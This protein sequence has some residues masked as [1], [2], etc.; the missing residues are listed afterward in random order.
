MI[1]TS[2]HLLRK[3]YNKCIAPASLQS[4][5]ILTGASSAAAAIVHRYIGCLFTC[6][7]AVARVLFSGPYLSLGAASGTAG[8]QRPAR[9]DWRSSQAPRRWACTRRAS[10]RGGSTE[11]SVLRRST[12]AGRACRIRRS[13]SGGRGRGRGGWGADD[14]GESLTI[15]SISEQVSNI[16]AT[17]GRLYSWQS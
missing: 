7:T 1:D 9:L 11:G 10:R 12:V 14:V 2:S 5:L 16:P 15:S 4:V 8:R 13:H 17:I 6:G 3:R